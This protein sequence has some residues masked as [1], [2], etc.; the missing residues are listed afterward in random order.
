MQDPWSRAPSPDP[1]QE[2]WE[3]YVNEGREITDR[4]F[5]D[6]CRENCKDPEDVGS[7]I[8]YEEWTVERYNSQRH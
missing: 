1:E 4:E 6:W 7:A 8:E 5:L 3:W 2:W